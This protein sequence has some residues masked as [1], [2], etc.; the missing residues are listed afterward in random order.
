MNLI[1]TIRNWRSYRQTVDELGRLS[2]RQLA[3]VGVRRDEIPSL[4]RRGL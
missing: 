4:A 2:N 3:D 1:R